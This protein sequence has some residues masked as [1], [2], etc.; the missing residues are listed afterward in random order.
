M[1]DMGT[2]LRLVHRKAKKIIIP[3]NGVQLVTWAA[4][5]IRS[6]KQ[7]QSQVSL[8]KFCSLVM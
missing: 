5:L 4:G 6:Y 8:F 7:S 1:D 2:V 3:G